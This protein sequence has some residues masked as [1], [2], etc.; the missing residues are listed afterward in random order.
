MNSTGIESY[1]QFP[2]SMIHKATSPSDAINEAVTYAIWNFGESMSDS[3]VML[4]YTKYKKLHPD[5]IPD[6]EN[7][8]HRMLMAAANKLNV[9]IGSVAANEPYRATYMRLKKAGGFQVRLRPDIAWDA[10]DHKWHFMKLKTLCAV[11][12]AI[13]NRGAAQLDHRLLRA[14]VSGF[15]SPNE[16]SDGDMVPESTL[17]Y[18]LDHCHQ[19]QLYKLC[20]HNGL[21]WYGIAR[22]FASDL[23]LAKWVKKKHGKRARRPV[24][25]T[26]DIPD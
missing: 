11:Y 26:E 10:R 14:L 17:R 15:N 25:S 20:L 12:A 5:Q 18:W 22:G 9:N 1:F 16:C 19:R 24:I 2:L 23:D 8:I 7:P 4:N 3:D 6:D 13:G 21:R